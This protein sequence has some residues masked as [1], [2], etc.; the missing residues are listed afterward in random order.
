MNYEKRYYQLL[1]ELNRAR[2]RMYQMPFNIKVRDD[3]EE[4]EKNFMAYCALL[5]EKLL[6]EN[7]D[8]LK[9]LK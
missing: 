6:E 4:T 1:E 5:L 7:E 8:V 2:D 9:R 3:F